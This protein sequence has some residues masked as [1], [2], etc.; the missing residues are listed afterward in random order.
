MKVLITGGSGFIGSNLSIY[1]KNKGLNV[2]SLDSLFRDG[3]KLNVA[4]LKKFKIKNYKIDVRDKKKILNLK[5]F[6]LIIDCCA[7]PSVNK[8]INEIDR[9]ISTN[10]IG[11]LNILH[12]CVKDNA[13]IIFLSTSRVYS[14]KNLRNIV[15]YENINKK[16]KIN[17]KIKIS[18][19]TNQ[20]KS[21]YGFSKFGSELL[22][23]E[24]SY[25]HKIKYLI[26]R[27]G[28]VAGPWQFG[29]VDQ[30][31]MSLW[32]WRHINKKNLNYIGFGGNG[33]QERDVLHIEDLCRLI[34]MQIK[35]INKINNLTINSGGGL[36]NKIS[37]KNLTQICENVTHNKIKINRVKKTSIY[38]IPYYVSSNRD[39]K[40]I[41][42][43]TPKKNINQI[44]NDIYK[45]QLEN[46]KKL[47]KY[48]S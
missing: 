48:M 9:V 46:R 42:N 36:K 7:E 29:K 19:D 30:G 4:R 6:D 27:L 22:I 40:R 45:W 26:N 33:Y 32:S 2:Y 11:T 12:K 10:L 28:V 37:L 23:K 21:I 41:Y 5:K 24:F 14:I 18:F 1:L 17:K 15:K 8:S 25:L 34:H 43:W 20:A 16:L 47:K 38:D 44:I 35:K 31:F 3:S 39:A 13:K